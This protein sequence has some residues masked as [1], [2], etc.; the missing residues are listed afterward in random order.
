MA[1]NV[2][3]LGC[4]QK[5][6][7]KDASLQCTVCGLWIHKSCSGITNEVFNALANLFKDTGKAYWACRACNSYAEGMNHRLKKMEDK[8]T[9]AVRVGEE[10]SKEIRTLREEIDKKND[11]LEKRVTSGEDNIL[12]EMNDRERRRKN[13]VMYGVKESDKAEGR[14]RLEDDKREINNIFT[15]LDVNL[16]V[17][18]DAEFCRRIGP[19]GENARPLV[20]GFYTEWGKNTLLKYAK[21]LEGTELSTISIAPDLTRQQRKAEMELEQE[22]IRKNEELDDEDRSKNLEWQVVGRKGQRRLIKTVRREIP[23]R[24]RGARGSRGPAGRG[25]G[26]MD[27]R[28]RQREEVEQERNQPAK[29]GYRGRGRPPLSGSNRAT[30]GVRLLGDQPR[31]EIDQQVTGETDGAEEEEEEEMEASQTA[32][33]GPRLGQ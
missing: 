7:Q 24:A 5:L 29:R 14:Q 13:V 18:D 28:K 26:A 9:E 17:E 31:Q 22:A 1:N 12:E 25:R 10:N 23:S 32:E 16:S 30:L 2:D 11:Q 21:R 19:R 20:C 27:T 6:K 8:V 15:V 33:E 4:G 3:C